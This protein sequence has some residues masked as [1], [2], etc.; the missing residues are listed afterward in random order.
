MIQEINTIRDKAAK[1]YKVDLHLHSPLSRDWRNDATNTYTVSPYLARLANNAPIIDEHLKAYADMLIVKKIDIA[2]VTDHMKHSFGIKLAAYVHKNN[3]DIVVFPGIEITVKTKET[4]IDQFKIHVLAVFPPGISSDS[5]ERIF[6]HGTLGESDRNG[7]EVVEYDTLAC[8]IKEIQEARGIAIAAHIYTTNGARFA[9]T[10]AAELILEPSNQIASSEA[11]EMYKKVGESVKKELFRFDALQ[12]KE[13]IDPVHFLDK[14]GDLSIPLLLATDAHHYDRIG[15]E[16]GL[17]FIKLGRLSFD[18]LKEAF[19]FPETRIRFK[20]NLPE[21]KPPRILGIKI[22]GRQDN[23]KAFF[24]DLKIGF[25]DNLSCIIGPRGSGKSAMIDGMRYAMGYNRTLDE[26]SKVKGEV[27]KRQEYT[28]EESKIEIFYEKKDGVVHRI[29]ATYD[30]RERYNTKIFDLDNNQLHIEDVEKCGEYPLNL[31]GWNELEFLGE[32]PA[33]QRENLDKF[34]KELLALKAEKKEL[35]GKLKINMGKCS[36]QLDILESYFEEGSEKEQFTRLKEYE[37]D[38][39]KLNTKDLENKFK[40]LDKLNQKIDF[41]AQ[42]NGEI[43]AALESLS[44]M[45][46]I[47]YEEILKKFNGINQWCNDFL[48]KRLEIQKVNDGLLKTK[49]TLEGNIAAILEIINKERE[50]LEKTKDEIDKSVRDVIG[51]EES[52]SADLRNNAKKR[53]DLAKTQFETYKKDLNELR[54]LLDQRGEIIRSIKDVNQRIFATRDREIL[55]IKEKISLVNEDDFV[56]ELA[57]NQSKDQGDFLKELNEKRCGLEFHGNWK[58]KKIPHVIVSKHTPFSFAEAIMKN[59]C[60]SII[61]DIEILENNTTTSYRID[62]EYASRFF[63]ENLPYDDIED[64]SIRRYHK[65]KMLNLL[66]IH[67]VPFDDEFFILLGG[68]PIQYCSPGQRCSA[69]LPIVTLTSDAP[70]IIDQ[71][72]DNLDNRLVSRAIFKILSKLKETRQI[73]LATHN[74]NILVSGDVEQVIVLKSNGSV[75]DYGSIDEPSI[76]Q[77][78]I[79]LMEGGKEAFEKRNKRYAQYL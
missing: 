71:P 1:F 5:I 25:S 27:L 47:V 54:G 66:K 62:E 16:S 56:I 75:E 17:S 35:Y 8:A 73:I 43:E 38:F 63:Q 7:N 50:D 49:K 39:Q 70:I 45:R 52:I 58:Q 67:E 61:H 10:K 37:K 22:I 68:K 3:L 4:L 11:S 53:L 55:N 40:R 69:M 24:K 9:Y 78:V 79:D 32:N 57:L 31:Y 20:N 26:I 72:E 74:P 77:N 46:Q 65:Q 2:A 51:K 48:D 13:T 64:L 14:N 76:I 23:K 15:L 18:C 42:L 36:Q 29:E 34:I 60:Q 44:E 28:L 59:D 33:S 41:L 21:T 6:P 12:V 19:K 30:G